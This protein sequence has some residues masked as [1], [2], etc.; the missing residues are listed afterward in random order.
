MPSNH[1]S[2][3]QRRTEVAELRRELR[4][5]QSLLSDDRDDLWARISEWLVESY[6]T[7]VGSLRT[8]VRTRLAD[9]QEN[10]QHKLY[11]HPEVDRGEDAFPAACE[12]CPHYGV[13]CPV[14]ARRT[15]KQTLAR[16]FEEAADDDELQ[17][18]LAEYAADHHCQV[19]QQELE[20]WQTGYAQFLARGEQLRIE[21]NADIAGIDLDDVQPDLARTR[22][23]THA[24]GDDD[25]DGDGDGD[26]RAPA[27]SAAAALAAAG[28]VG[29]DAPGAG[30]E[31]AVGGAGATAG[32]GGAAGG[33]MPPEEV[34]ERVA[35]VTEA[36]RADDDEDGEGQA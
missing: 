7:P 26:G 33:E 18:R 14:L 11:D 6:N 30:V 20:E 35:A 31:A 17:Q 32:G 25:G 29:G 12:G 15:S 36:V 8:K 9:L 5:K 23:Q 1:A 22:T 10:P 16:I 28:G 21:L 2:G 19:I 34:R 13:Q 3:D 4:D 27:A 24:A